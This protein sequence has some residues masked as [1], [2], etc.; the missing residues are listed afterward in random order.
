MLIRDETRH[1][2][3]AIRHLVI[4]AFGQAAEADLVDALRLSGD[5]VISLV[6]EDDG[7]IVGHILFSKLQ[8]PDQCAALAPVSVA[9]GRQNQGIGSRLILE[10]LARAKHDDWQALFVVGD[11]EYYERFGFSAAAADKFETKYPKRYFMALELAPHSLSDRAGALIYA[12]PFV[13]LDQR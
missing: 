7:E 1:D 2:A 6:A 12:P 3:S 8:V 4:A 9:P 11:P 5:A 10:G 13:A